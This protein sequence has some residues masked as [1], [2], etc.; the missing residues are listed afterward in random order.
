MPVF[1]RTTRIFGIVQMHCP[2]I[3]ETYHPVKFRKH[4]VQIPSDVIPCIPYMT[5]IK[6]DPDLLPLVLIDPVQNLTQ[7][8]KC[9]A[10]LRSLPCHRLQ[11]H[12]RTLPRTDIAIH[13]LRNAI[14][15]TLLILL[16]RVSRMEIEEIARKLLH[17]R[18][19]ISKALLR[20][21][22]C[23]LFI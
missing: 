5:G 2:Q 1:V 22:A 16:Q 4:A 19:I 21:F 12:N 8:F 23:P 14:H 11:Q 10:E 20:I 7:L 9:S 13:N 3:P 17:F 15:A 18:Q 6:A